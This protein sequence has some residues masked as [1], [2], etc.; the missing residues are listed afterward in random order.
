MKRIM[1]TYDI[2]IV[3]GGLAGLSALSTIA[4]ESDAA[5]AL[6]EGRGIGSN[7]PTPM[8]FVDVGERFELEDHV[9]GRYRQFTFHSP[10]GNRSNHAY[11]TYPLITLDYHGAC[12][13]LL[14]RGQA[15][16]NV[17]VIAGKAS[18]LQRTAG[19]RWRVRTSEG[20]VT[21][22][23]LIDASGCALFA[24]RSLN[25]PGPRMFSHCFGQIFTGCTAP[26][27]EKAFFFAPSDRFGDGGGWL[28]PLADGR[29]SFGYASLSRTVDYPGQPVRERYYRALREFA[30]YADWLA[31]AQPDHVERGT[32]PVCPPRRFVYNGLVLVGDAAGQ[33]TIWSCMGSEPAL[34][35]GQWAG[36]A[37]VEAHRR[38]DYSF[39]ALQSYQ[40]RWDRA[41]RRIYR[42]GALL[43]PVS[44][45]QGEISWNRQ[46]PLLQQLGPEQMLARLRT[47]WPL[48]PWRKIALVRAYAWAGRTR[49]RMMV[50]T[51]YDQEGSG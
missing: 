4:Q 16:G 51:G 1:D 47:N 23:L 13:K 37:A 21:T 49:R 11:D 46:I 15:A 3:G 44:W 41:Y 14:H 17:A 36:W 34:V 31:D 8:T 45:G 7:N 40:Q 22:P 10:L 25:L 19:D 5:I 29:I 2:V 20:Q 18:Q 12:A 39:T 26:D 24:T 48:L 6:I 28:Y 33:A 38:R 42:Q 43:A 9:Q 32:I 27:P 35:S 50:W 30:P